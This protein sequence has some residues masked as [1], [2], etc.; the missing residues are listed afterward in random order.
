LHLNF[1]TNLEVADE[2]FFTQVMRQVDNEL[3]ASRE[4]TYDA[5]H[6]RPLPRRLAENFCYLFQPML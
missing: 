5:H 6:S 3:A 2:A 4:V 1:E